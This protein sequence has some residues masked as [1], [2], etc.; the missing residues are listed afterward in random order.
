MV[1]HYIMLKDQI[2]REVVVMQLG[3]IMALVISESILQ[4]QCLIL[5]MR[6]LVMLVIIV[7]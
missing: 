5:D 1:L 3:L 6:W 2:L 7:V 4:L